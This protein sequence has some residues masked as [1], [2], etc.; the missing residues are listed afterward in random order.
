MGRLNCGAASPG[1]ANANLNIA[2]QM[3]SVNENVLMQVAWHFAKTCLWSEIVDRF[4][5]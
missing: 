1:A 5:P 3:S 4:M 2:C